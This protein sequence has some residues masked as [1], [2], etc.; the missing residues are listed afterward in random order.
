LPPELA[1]NSGPYDEELHILGGH[2]RIVSGKASSTPSTNSTTQSPSSAGSPEGQYHRSSPK[3][4]APRGFTPEALDK[5]HPSLLADLR[6]TK[7]TEPVVPTRYARP[8]VF[9]PTVASGYEQQ[10][11][12]QPKYSVPHINTSG[13]PP[14]RQAAQ[15]ALDPWGGSVQPTLQSIGSSGYV[16]APSDTQGA[17][18]T[19]GGD[20]DWDMQW[21]SFMDQLG[22][23]SNDPSAP[24][25]PTQLKQER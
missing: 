2:T 11:Y 17:F 1:D 25:A 5:A 18:V 10:A 22:M 9:K 23:F 6:T 24:Y 12:P 14:C 4:N 20:P 3:N 15:P 7:E 16:P 13:P 21:H 8:S 19:V